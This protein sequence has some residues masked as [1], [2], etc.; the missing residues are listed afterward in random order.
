MKEHAGWVFKRVREELNSGPGT[1]KIQLSKTNNTMVEGNK[2]HIFSLMKRLGQDS[3]VQPGKF[4]FTPIPEVVEVF[5]YLH[6]T[7]ECIV[8]DK[9]KIPGDKF[10]LKKCLKLLRYSTA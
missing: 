7:L 1:H 5:I 8:K 2:Y 9:L 10:I 6:T 3:L 4:L